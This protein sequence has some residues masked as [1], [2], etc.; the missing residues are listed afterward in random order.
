M[1]LRHAILDKADAL[2]ERNME[3]EWPAFGL[4][5]GVHSDSGSDFPSATFQRACANIGIAMDYPPLGAPHFGGH[6]ESLIGTAQHEM[7]LLPGATSS[8][9]AERGDYHSDGSA[10]LTLDELET[11]LWRFIAGD[12]NVRIHSA[13]GLPPLVAWRRQGF[14]PRMPRDPEHLAFEFLLGAAWTITRQGV[15]FT[16]LDVHDLRRCFFAPGLEVTVPLALSQP[17]GDP[18]RGLSGLLSRRR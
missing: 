11:W 7:H 4:R 13:T 8:N 10:A 2:R 18:R 1:A 5:D 15:V 14:A 17:G 12:Y 6:I 16:R 3:A 9:I